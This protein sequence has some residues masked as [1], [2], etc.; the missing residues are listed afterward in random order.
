M[1]IFDWR[2]PNNRKKKQLKVEIK[3][4]FSAIFINTIK[5]S[6][7]TNYTALKKILGEA[8]RIEAVKQTNN[9][10]YLWDELG[11][12]CSTNSPERMLM[13]L[14]VE[15]NRYGLGHQP[16]NNFTGDVIIDGQPMLDAI[17]AVNEDRPYI[18][19]SIIKDNKQVA[20]AIGWN[21]SIK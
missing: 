5:I 15:D 21:P 2:N 12:Y 11:I 1:G 17:Q 20:I 9:N 14:L 6:F 18:I 3:C 19:R 16:L 4:D 13:L 8:S 10:V 7:P